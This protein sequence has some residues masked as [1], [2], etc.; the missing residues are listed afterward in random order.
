MKSAAMAAAGAFAAVKLVDFAKDA[1]GAASDLNESA[2]KVATVFGG[3]ARSIQNWSKTTATSIGLSQQEALDAA[4]A[5]GNMFTQIGISTDSAA[6]MSTTMS[7][8][9]ADFA[10]FHNADIT[11]VLEAQQAAF[12]GEYDAVQKF[13]PTINA[14]AVEQ[15]ALADTHKTSADQLTANEKA[16][17]TY[18]LMVEGA[19]AAQG[20][21]ART[22]DSMANQQRIASAQWKDAQATLG[23][24]LLPVLTDLAGVLTGSIIP[25]FAAFAGF[26]QDN[27]GWIGPLAAIIATLVAGIKLWTIAQAA[28]NVVMAMNPIGLIVVAIA[29]LVAGLVIAYQKVD[30]FRAAVDT[31]ARAA[32]AAFNFLWN[33]IKAVFNWIVDHWQLVVSIIAGPIGIAVAL[34]ISHWDKVKAALNVLW[35]VMQ[36]VWDAIGA[37]VRTYLAVLAQVWAGVQAIWDAMKAAVGAVAS[38][39]TA[40]FS[41]AV[42]WFSSTFGPTIS[43][44]IST[45]RA[46]WDGMVSAAQQAA[47]WI[48]SAF[49]GVVG[50]FSGIV[51]RIAGAL[52]GVYNAIISP[53]KQALDWLSDIPGKIKSIIDKIPGAGAISNIVGSLNP[54]SA[55]APAP[56]P[57]GGT[58]GVWGAAAVSA[59]AAGAP[60]LPQ[61]GTFVGRSSRR[62]AVGAGGNTYQINVDV[63]PNHNPVEV[64]R[65]IVRTIRAFEGAAGAGWRG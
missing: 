53:F 49:D 19:G 33:A 54:F 40:A 47:G 26:V 52:S 25:A 50:F 22:S 51:S 44:V 7:G 15:R 27:I 32:V 30:W 24:A 41:G 34:I 55:P 45:V 46:A 29:A 12:R 2:S 4:G 5:F 1:V 58:A 9:A 21:F 48:K 56:A 57:R 28:L 37:V 43:R 61:T 65:A 31:M 18:A 60:Y 6:G 23:Q 36:T 17:A 64:G 39:I 62:A 35:N 11:D 8:L 20:D 3:S 63:A 10:S 13:V 42:N 14:A 16:M 38:A 59:R